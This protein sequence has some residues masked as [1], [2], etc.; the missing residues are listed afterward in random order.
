[1]EIRSQ[2]KKG[3]FCRKGLISIVQHSKALQKWDAAKLWIREEMIYDSTNSLL[4]KIMQYHLSVQSKF[5]FRLRLD[6]IS[7]FN[8]YDIEGSCGIGK[9]DYF[10]LFI[11]CQ[12]NKVQ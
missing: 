1:M 7:S 8:M 12:I 6:F 2:L 4:Q 10:S 11:F 9:S 3:I 5:N